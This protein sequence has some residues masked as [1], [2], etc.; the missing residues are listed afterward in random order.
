MGRGY[1]AHA[2]ARREVE[3]AKRADA[4]RGGEM[5]SQFERDRARVLHS[6]AFRR[7]AD[8]TQV[9]VPGSDD[10]PRTRLTHSLEVAQIGREMGA[11]LGCDP[12]VVDTA[13][14]AHD[15]GHPPFGHNG[16]L[17][18]NLAAAEIGGFEGNA[19][20][21]R[22]LT[23]LEAKVLNSQGQPAGLNLTRATLDAV[24]KYP[25]SQRAGTPKFGVYADDRPAFEWVRAGAPAGTRCLEAQVMDWADD[26]AYSVHDVEDGVHAGHIRLE[27]IDDSARESLCELAAATYS[28]LSAGELAPVLDALLELPTLRDLSGYDR[29]Y[30]A[31]TAAKRATSELTGRFVSAAV[32]ATRQTYGPAPMR[33]YDGDLVVPSQT[34]AECAL[35]KAVA[36]QYVMSRPGVLE[37]QH[38]QRVLLTELVAALVAASPGRL[39]VPLQPAWHAADSDAA[40]LRVVIDQVAQLTDTSAQSWHTRLCR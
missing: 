12:D 10:F 38:D 27:N 24:C 8:K 2:A 4:D 37:R 28:P 7:L 3:P 11:A 31:Q 18:L 23:R 16:E 6:Y 14:L 17:A 34:A 30:L 29:S 22:I 40:R 21:L 35:L 1:D 39:D 36:A 5:R 32:S 15:L 25:W 9:V 20:T 26:V 19:Q 13:G 33:R